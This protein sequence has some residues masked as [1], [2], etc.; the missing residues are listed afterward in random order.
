M[1]TKKPRSL[2]L[3]HKH[4]WDYWL[5]GLLI[6]FYPTGVW[7]VSSGGSSVFN[8]LGV[9]GFI[10]LAITRTWPCNRQQNLVL[11]TLLLYLFVTFVSWFINGMEDAAF[12]L[13]RRHMLFVLA[14]FGMAWLAW[15]RPSAGFFWWG[16]VTASI[17]IGLT[18]LYIFSL[19]KNFRS[20][21]FLVTQVNP[22]VFGQISVVLCALT[23]A[24][25]SYF[26]R[27]GNWAFLFP[28]LGTILSL[29]AAIGSATRG[30]W[31]ALPAMLI[32]IIWHYR[33]SLLE[34]TGKV[35]TGFLI[36]IIIFFMFSGW[37]VIQ[38]RITQAISEVQNYFED[39][40]KKVSPSGTRLDMWRAAFESGK[41]APIFGPGK[42]QYL[43]EIKR[44]VKTGKYGW[45]VGVRHFPHSEYATAFGYHGIAGLLSLILVFL[46][47]CYIFWKRWRHPYGRKKDSIGLAGLIIV[48]SFAI[49][50]MTDSPFE[51]RPTIMFFSIMMLITLAVNQTESDKEDKSNEHVKL[52]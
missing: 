22:I 19:D 46:I 31:L 1:V 26:R 18:G 20:G 29:M 17:L 43:R 23:A 9:G 8:I 41:N 35:L 34:N 42:D 15:R 3:F 14:V 44:G 25:F 10:M 27:L 38:E 28:A 52:P 21:I 16:V 5:L 48:I 39:P 51:Q 47:P 6:F 37:D 11:L 4:P 2:H 40:E 45:E 49:F 50:S 7:L 24:S 12:K 36:F 32:L 13:L 33:R 30:A